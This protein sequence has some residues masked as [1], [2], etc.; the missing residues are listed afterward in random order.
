MQASG[1]KGQSI[2]L[3]HRGSPVCHRGQSCLEGFA[4]EPQKP[5]CHHTSPATPAWSSSN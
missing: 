2:S 5:V 1:V 3:A 4:A